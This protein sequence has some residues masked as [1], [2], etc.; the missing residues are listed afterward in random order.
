MVMQPEPDEGPV[1]VAIEYR[2]DPPKVP[3]FLNA[4]LDYQRIRS[5]GG[6]MR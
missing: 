6:A 4:L 5:R 1:P 2:V 3:E